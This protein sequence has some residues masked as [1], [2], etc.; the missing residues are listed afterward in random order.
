MQTKVS[1]LKCS[2]S[3]SQWVIHELLMIVFTRMQYNSYYDDRQLRA[4]LH[5]CTVS[6]AD[7]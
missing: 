3:C 5:L 1:K 6:T 2:D 4:V 7:T